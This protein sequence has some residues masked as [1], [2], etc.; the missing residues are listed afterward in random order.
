[1]VVIEEQLMNNSQMRDVSEA[2]LASM[3]E[4]EFAKWQCEQG[5]RVICHRSRYWQEVIPGF[6]E[7]IHWMANLSA[8]QATRPT[9]FCWGFRASL[10]QNDAVTANGT[11]PVHV[12]SNIEN[13]D[14]QS[15]ESKRRNK[16]RKCYKLVKIVELTDPVLLQEQGYEAVLSAGTR[17]G[18]LNIPSK[19]EY[20]AS[21]TDYIAPG[22]RLVLAGLI[23]DKLGGYLTG[24]AVSGTAYIESRYIKTEVLPT[25][26]SVGLTFEFVQFCRRSGNIHQ[27]VSG[28]HRPEDPDLNVF[29]KDMG[30]PVKH[31]PTRIW[32]NPIIRNFIR[33]RH[34]HKYY[35]LTGHN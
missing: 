30:F 14:F 27:V 15:L 23:D 1:V 34:P 10:R 26:I 28:L 13:Y 16:L 32:M 35:R 12:L 5:K 8:E 22:R 6:Y 24:Y 2:V 21:L 31:I 7:P 9:P 19:E 33:W 11:M 29:K 18:N 4:G 25:N 20:L 17:V 3:S